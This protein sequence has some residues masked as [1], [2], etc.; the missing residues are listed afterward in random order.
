MRV[1]TNGTVK[2]PA[3]DPRE[4][5]TK[6]LVTQI[7]ASQ[8]AL[9]VYIRSLIGQGSQVDDVLQEVNLVLWRKGHE[10]DGSGRFLPGL[11]RQVRLIDCS[12]TGKVPA[13]SKPSPLPLVSLGPEA[14]VVGLL[15][16]FGGHKGHRVGDLRG[17]LPMPA[18]RAIDYLKEHD[19]HPET[20]THPHRG[21][22][23]VMPLL[24]GRT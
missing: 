9:Y 13:A 16:V 12:T 8:R 15:R 21:Q 23:S 19:D 17:A 20:S 11:S 18:Q 3:V 10:F 7:A 2:A 24:Q 6:E 1:C 4:S 22:I 14:M 5:Q